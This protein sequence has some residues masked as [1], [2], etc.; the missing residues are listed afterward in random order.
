M[1]NTLFREEAKK[2]KVRHWEVADAIGMLD[3]NFCRKLRKELPAHEQAKL[4]NIVHEIA[5]SREQEK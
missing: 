3:V 5:A 4:I 1:A 2:Y